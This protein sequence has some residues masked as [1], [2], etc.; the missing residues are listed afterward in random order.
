MPTQ[1]QA[2]PA[3]QVNQFNIAEQSAD[4]SLIQ[5][6]KQADLTIIFPFAKVKNRTANALQGTYTVEQGIAI[7]LR[8]TGLVAEFDEK[9]ALT[10]SQQEQTNNDQQDNL[11]SRLLDFLTAQRNDMVTYPEPEEAEFELIT[12][13]GIRASMQRS[14]DVKRSAFNIVDAIQAEEIGKFPDQ[15]LAE[16][17]QRITGV[18]IDRS[19]GEGQF[20]TVRGFG[21][22]FNTVLT[23]GR[24]LATDNQGREFSFDTLASELVSGV[25]VHKTIPASTQSGG[26]GS[27]IDIH[28]ARPLDIPGFKAAGS[29]KALYDTNSEQSSPQGTLLLSHSDEEGRWGILMSMAYQKRNARINEVQTDGW[30]LNTNIPTQ[31]LHS[32]AA[33]IFVPRN[34]DQRVRFDERT[35]SGGTLVLQYQP[36][37]ALKLSAD[38]LTSD[39]QVKTDSSSMGHWFTSSNLEN[40]YTDAN[41]TVVEFEQKVGHATDFHARTFDRPSKL[42]AV[43]LNAQWQ[44]SDNLQLDFDMSLS[45]AKLED[46]RGAANALSLI[47]YLNRSRFDHSDGNILPAISGFE[48]AD[49]NIL[50][51]QG[52]PSGVSDYLDPSNGR[53]HVML[54]RGWNI[55]DELDQY[56]MD[57]SWDGGLEHL[58]KIKFGLF[59]TRRSKQNQRW[60]NEANGLHCSFCGYFD[61]PDIPDD[62]QSVFDAGNDFLSSVSGNDNI[63]KQWL[64][65]DGEQLF[66][67]LQNSSGISLEASAR[68]N[69]FI[70][71]ENYI[72]SYV[73]VDLNGEWRNMPIS[74]Q[75]GLRYEDTAVEVSG[76]EAELIE[77]T[78]LDQTELGQVT[79][80]PRPIEVDSHYSNLLP[81]LNL[82]LEISSALIARMALSKSLTRPTMSQMSPSLVLNTTRQG[83]DL[84]ASSGNPALRPFASS[85]FDMALEWYYDNTSHLAASYFRKKVDNFII[86]TVSELT[87]DQVKD[88]STGEDPNH[89]DANDSIAS[90]ELTQPING[91]TATVDGWELAIQHNFTNTGFGVLANMTIVDSNA[92]LDRNDITQKFA[93]TGLS[94]SQNFIAYYQNDLVQ[95]RLAWNHRDGF[96]QSLVQIQGGEPTFVKGYHQLDFS[97]SYVLN[98]NI[99]V[100][101]EGINITEQVVGKHGRYDNQLLLVQDTGARYALG[102]RGSF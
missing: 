40:V 60:D 17:L 85:N 94:D 37:T 24:R 50:D 44:A 29:I 90:F 43:G 28:T 49:P 86:S 42:Q 56:S 59:Y 66:E 33:N 15:N 47:G 75:L 35:R 91:E 83:G 21:P 101:F 100:I 51:A 48:L 22:Q 84:R 62:F 73:Q 11:F 80:T 52:Q 20:V 6:A 93:L 23:N 102:L 14:M 92:Q 67:F 87:F 82:K 78:I 39:F 5:F 54:R 32:D 76:I 74:A 61:S 34:Y 46:T 31:Q 8:D 79:T 38:Y 4:E 25:E 77:L 89:P 65:H 99:S 97:A 27:T 16:S 3:P 71:D 68:N 36:N 72:A 7:L 96:L 69:S 13:K 55:R 41:G 26:I 81:G 53:A 70:V 45:Q 12:V 63:P 10:I 18:S 9:G 88:P 64:R 2:L 1:G 57:G 98:E 95:L 30:L 19:E 58:S